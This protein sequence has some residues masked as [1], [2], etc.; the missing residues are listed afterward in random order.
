MNLVTEPGRIIASGRS[1]DVFEAGPGRVL[2]RYREPHDLRRQADVIER[3]VA[4]G[5]PAPR[6]LEVGDYDLVVE[7]VEG[8][9]MFEGLM[10][11]PERLE[12]D[13]KLLADLHERLHAIGI[14]HHDLHPLNV[15]FGPDGP[16]VIDWESADEAGG[17]T[18][19]A[20]TW[21]LLA[22]ADIPEAIRPL[23]DRFLEAFLSH[24]DRGAARRAL[25]QAIEH[26]RYDPHMT[27]TELQ[28]MDELFVS[29]GLGASEPR[30]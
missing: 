2:I 10:L 4:A 15:I 19:V 16:V 14:C 7:R 5:F 25:S 6:V 29:E 30:P 26:R 22:T 28:R 12:A 13:A 24:V 8:P 21:L 11:H 17:P 18:D 20:E 27:K 3:V 1:A 9:T 23:A